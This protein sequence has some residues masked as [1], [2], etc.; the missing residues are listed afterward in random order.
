MKAIV[1]EQTGPIRP[2]DAP[3]RAIECPDPHPGEG[4]VRLRVR[5][6][7]VCHTELD[8]IEGRTPPSQMP[9][10]LGHQVVGEI[11]E[12]GPQVDASWRGARVGVAWIFGACGVCR[13]CRTGRENLCAKFLATGRDA[14]GGYAQR[15]IAPVA[16][17]HRLPAGL[18]DEQVAPLLCAGA[19][20]LRSLDLTEL[21]DGEP[22][23]LT[24]FGASG[25]LVLALSR[26]LYP[27]SPVYVFARSADERALARERGAVWTGDAADRSPEPLAAMIDTTPVWTPV[28]RALDQLAPGGRLVVNAIR[29]E[30]SDKPVLLEL[31]YARHL[32]REKMVRSVAN[33]TRSDVRRCLALA[34]EHGIRPEVTTYPLAQANE[35]LQSL[36][37][38]RGR[39]ARV[40]I[41]N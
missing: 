34:A 10:I 9:R 25:H 5:A 28:L 21:A 18:T 16:F 27:R 1:L 6:C 8:E 41:V 29:K 13:F 35:A 38:G 39:G 33:V 17:V 30:E 24:G 2:G 23:G 19:I 12:L 36:K 7:G 4:D 20:G 14:D 22:L 15:M 31:D 3:L 11:D 26:A 32:W 40:L 37:E